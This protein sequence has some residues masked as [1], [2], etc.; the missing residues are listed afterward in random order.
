MITI[1]TG[2]L[3]DVFPTETFG[4]FKKCVFWLQELNSKYP[5]T[6]AIECWHDDAINEMRSYRVGDALKVSFEVKG[7]HWSKG[8]REGVINTLKMVLIERVKPGDVSD[9]PAAEETQREVIRNTGGGSNAASVDDL[10]F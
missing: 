3:L 8:G 4:A 10:P 9:V 2:V 1:V 5:N 7:K 6:W